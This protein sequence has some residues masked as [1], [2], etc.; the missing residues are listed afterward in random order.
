VRQGRDRLG[1]VPEAD[2][3]EHRV[4]RADWRV[5]DHRVLAGGIADV[6]HLAIGSEDAAVRGDLLDRR[7]TQAE[8]SDR[9]GLRRGGADR[10]G[11]ARD[12]LAV[13]RRVEDLA[14]DSVFD[15]QVVR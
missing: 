14:V 13:E 4:D 15:E 1:P 12:H 8:V 9:T 3:L 10:A 11:G 6:L 7:L 2:Y 5:A